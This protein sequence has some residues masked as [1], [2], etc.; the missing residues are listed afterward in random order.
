ME[1]LNPSMN[2]NVNHQ[3]KFN[4]AKEFWMFE[5]AHEN[6]IMFIVFLLKA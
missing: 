4:M 5:K 1:F 2:Y 6:E 3:F